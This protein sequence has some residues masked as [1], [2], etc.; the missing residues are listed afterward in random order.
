M[1]KSGLGTELVHDLVF[2]FVIYSQT[3][4]SLFASAATAYSGASSIGGSIDT[5]DCTR[6]NQSLPGGNCACPTC[7][8]R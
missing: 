2:H 5:G 3:A 1:T 7:S 4:A 8:T 6:N